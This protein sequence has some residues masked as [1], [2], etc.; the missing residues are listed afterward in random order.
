MTH[1]MFAVRRRPLV[2]V[3]TI[4]AAKEDVRRDVAEV[5]DVYDKDPARLSLLRHQR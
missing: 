4:T 3:V 5:T 1:I 2:V